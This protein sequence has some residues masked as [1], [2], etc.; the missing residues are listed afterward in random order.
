M[1]WLYG[2]F[3]F[4][5]RAIISNFYDWIKTTGVISEKTPV[6]SKNLGEFSPF[7]NAILGG[8]IAAGFTAIINNKMNKR[9][10][11]INTVTAERVKWLGILR[12]NFADFESQVIHVS[13]I[14]DC[15][16][17]DEKSKEKVFFNLFC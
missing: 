2:L 4:E 14:K 7:A 10:S 15:L 8:V 17:P 16:E 6:L 12:E 5:I 13:I 9:S 1:W 3:P 11:Y